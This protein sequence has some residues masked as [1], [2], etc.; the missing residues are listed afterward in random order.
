MSGVTAAV[1]GKCD[2]WRLGAACQSDSSEIFFPL[3]EMVE[4]LV[5]PARA[6]CRA[7]PVVVECLAFAIANRQPYGVWGGLTTPERDQIGRAR[8]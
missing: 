3:N 7:C 1:A 4:E 5:A 8:R 6:I 2:D